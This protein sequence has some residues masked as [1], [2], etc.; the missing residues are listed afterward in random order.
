MPNMSSNVVGFFL[1]AY[2]GELLE[3][4]AAVG[5]MDFGSG[6]VYFGTSVF[7]PKK[8]SKNDPVEPAPGE[9]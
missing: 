2:W 7:L 9:F 4:L 3:V 5:G 6:L 8:L 1:V